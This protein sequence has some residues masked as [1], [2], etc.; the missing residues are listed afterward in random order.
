MAE[1]TTAQK[2]E[3]QELQRLQKQLSDASPESRAAVAATMLEERRADVYETR[4]V[5]LRDFIEMPEYLNL[6]GRV[7]PVIMD[8]A[9]EVNH[10]EVRE[11]YLSLGKGSGKSTLCGILMARWVYELLCKR[12]PQGHYGLLPDSTLTILNVSTSGEQAKRVVFASFMARVVNAPC[13]KGKYRSFTTRCVFP[14]NIQVVCGH[15]G[16]TSFLGYDTLCAV[17]DETSWM[18]D[19]SHKSLAEDIYDML[20]GS[21]KTRF[22]Q[23]YKLVEISSPRTTE[24]FLTQQ[25][26]WVKKTGQSFELGRQLHDIDGGAD[27]GYREDGTA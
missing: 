19:T 2:Q 10:P 6:R 24:D 3:L 8:M 9:Q 23:R 25:V 18:L 15:S 12:D 14:K 20:V 21:L 4:P 7:Y 27:A 22:A 16:S 17:M 26:E 13:F 11:A 5:A 1:L